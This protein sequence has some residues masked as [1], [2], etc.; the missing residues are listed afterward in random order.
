MVNAPLQLRYTSIARRRL[1]GIPDILIGRSLD[2]KSD[3]PKPPSFPGPA[4]AE[5]PPGGSPGDVPLL[6][7]VRRL[8]ASAAH[9]ATYGGS[10]RPLDHQPIY[11]TTA[12]KAATLA[13]SGPDTGHLE[14]NDFLTYLAVE[15]NVAASTQ[16][17]ALSGLLF[18]YREVLQLPITFDAV[19]AKRPLRVP[20]VLSIDEVRARFCGR[21]HRGPIRRRPDSCTVPA[22]VC[23]RPVAPYALRMSISLDSCITVRDGKGNRD[24]LVPLPEK[25]VPPLKQQL[26]AVRQQHARDVSPPAPVR[27]LG[28][29]MRWPRNTLTPGRSLAWQFLFPAANTSV[30]PRPADLN[31]L[32]PPQIRRQHVH[33]STVQKALIARDAPSASQ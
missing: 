1:C 27:V 14:I 20:V 26:D 2:I 4:E 30:D 24:R 12:T 11:A 5:L 6:T 21:F 31:A 3:L 25:L 17:Q 22:C 33:A 15:K 19:R 10:L 16:N 29:P 9:V 13:S 28:S 32:S 8:H 7:R 18:L 23:S